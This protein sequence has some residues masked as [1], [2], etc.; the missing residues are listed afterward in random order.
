[1][2]FGAVA[3]F[4]VTRT[5]I[6]RSVHMS[7]WNS[8]GSALLVANLNGK[9]LERIDITRNRRGKIIGATFNKS[10]SLGVGKSMTVEEGAK[11]YLGKN[12]Q[13]KNM[14]GSILG[15]YNKA[16][17]S[18]LTP[19]GNCKE[20]GCNKNPVILGGRTNNVI[21]CPIV[22]KGDN[23][24]ITFGGGGLLVANTKTTPMRIVGEYDN[25]VFNGAGCGGVQVGN[26][27]W[28]N[29]GVSASSAGATQSTFTMYAID[30]TEFSSAVNAPNI[31]EP[32]LVY[33]DNT[34]TATIGNIEGNPNP[35]S[36][37]QLPGI[38]TRRDAHGMAR[39]LSGLYI[40]NVDRIQNNVEVFNTR[41]LKRSTYDLASVDGKGNGVGPCGAV[42]VTDDDGLPLNDPAP[43]LVENTPDGKFLVV[44]LRGPVPVSVTH[45]AQGSCPG[46]GII[47]LR[48]RG[49]SG[50]LVGVLRTTNTVDT[51][52]AN[53]P[54]GHAYTG[55][56]HS[57]IHG[58]S[59]R[60]K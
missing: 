35:N 20:N 29:S 6:G 60:R 33:K 56:E 14:I 58:A 19:N 8:D 11:V 36:T 51:A 21:I 46:V 50:R 43:D 1:M 57:D 26:N 7:F 55:K 54:G 37:G 28:L 30:D 52:P 32:V 34:N 4:R 59:V 16:G 48:K 53:A 5:N 47:K 38:T 15:N 40:H 23:A 13:G 24:Y 12:S 3:L 25:Q 22:S 10:A 17:F 41:T 31:P 44:A 45:A 9:V 2:P 49:A 27:M 42:S 18:D 39:T